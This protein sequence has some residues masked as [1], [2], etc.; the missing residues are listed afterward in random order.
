MRVSLGEIDTT[1]QKVAVALGLGLGLGVEAGRAALAMAAADFDPAPAFAEAFDALDGDA[2]GDSTSS[3][4][5]PVRAI[6]RDFAPARDGTRLSALLAAPS[7]CDLLALGVADGPITVRAVDVPIV[8]LMT[9]LSRIGHAAESIRVA[10]R[11]PNEGSAICGGNGLH[12][13]EGS[14]DMASGPADISIERLS[15]S[16]DRGPDAAPERILGEHMDVDD[17]AWRRLTAH[18]DKCLVAGTDASRLTEAGA[19]LSDED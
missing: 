7:I 19:G 18:A 13:E 10:W 11:G 5:D 4:L 8:V 17:E 1:M 6:Q 2:L 16:P 12:F 3:G 15:T 9:V 14:G